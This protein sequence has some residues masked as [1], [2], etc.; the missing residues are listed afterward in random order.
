MTSFSKTDRLPDTV[1]EALVE[2]ARWDASCRRVADPIRGF[3]FVRVHGGE[4]VGP[5][6]Y[7]I[8]MLEEPEAVY[9]LVELSLIGL[10][11][12]YPASFGLQAASGEVLAV[13]QWTADEAGSS[14][15]R[16]GR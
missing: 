8:L 11:R 1:P 3:A 16:R 13:A 5:T 15:N 10:C 7:S 9:A 4:T 12:E 6:S 2:Q 14:S